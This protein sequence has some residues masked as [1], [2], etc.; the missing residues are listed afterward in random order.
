MKATEYYAFKQTAW[1]SVKESY[2]RLSGH[3]ELIIL[4]KAQGARLK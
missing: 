2:D 1:E 3:Y 4:Q